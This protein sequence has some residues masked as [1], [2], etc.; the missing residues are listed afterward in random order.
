M[1]KYIEDYALTGNCETV[2]PVSCDGSIEWL[3]LPR[4]EADKP[5]VTR[6][7][8][9]SGPGGCRNGEGGSCPIAIRDTADSF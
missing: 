7:G 5:D 4:L 1:P 6:A 2:A 3:G 9:S 8:Y